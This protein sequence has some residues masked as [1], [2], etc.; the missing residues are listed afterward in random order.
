NG[1]IQVPMTDNFIDG[2]TGRVDLDMQE[3]T[4]M[5]S[6]CAIAFHQGALTSSQITIIFDQ[7]NVPRFINAPIIIDNWFL[8]WQK[9]CSTLFSGTVHCVKEHEKVA[10]EGAL[11]LDDSRIN[12]SFLS[13]Q[14]QNIFGDVQLP[15]WFNAVDTWSFNGTCITRKPIAIDTALI[16]TQ[17]TLDTHITGSP[18]ALQVDGSVSFIGGQLYFPYKSLNITKGRLNFTGT[19]WQDAY[20]ELYAKNRIKRYMV[21]MH[22][23][24]FFAKPHVHFDAQPT[25]RQEQILALLLGGSEKGSLST[26]VPAIVVHN[27]YSW[28]FGLTGNAGET[29]ILKKFLHSLNRI[30]FVPTV[31]R[32]KGL[33]GTF[34]IDLTDKLHASIQKDFTNQEQASL[35]LEY[36]L[37]NALSLRGRRDERGDLE[38]DIEVRWKF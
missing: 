2:I 15:F 10:L 31:S 16:K 27:A 8:N 35:E 3:R 21:D 6:D 19:S 25:L 30:H 32:A 26:S 37:N 12:Q 14:M 33:Q 22:V 28:L 24:G 17:C 13:E 7:W 29:S 4:L 34:E 9:H 1:T 20:L 36:Q 38:A 23:S 5:I 11:F 18:R